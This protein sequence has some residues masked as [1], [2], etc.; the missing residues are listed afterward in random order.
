MQYRIHFIK[1]EYYLQ[2][3]ESAPLLF[4]IEQESKVNDHSCAYFHSIIHLLKTGKHLQIN[5][6]SASLTVR[7][8]SGG[9]D[10]PNGCVRGR[11]LAGKRFLVGARHT[12]PL[13]GVQVHINAVFVLPKRLS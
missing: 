5:F 9:G 4:Q 1:L 10:R 3:N 2:S 7:Y 6:I 11:H 12:F 13:P 8:G